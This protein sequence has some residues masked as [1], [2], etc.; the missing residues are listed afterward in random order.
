MR[1]GDTIHVAVS[2]IEKRLTKT[3]ERGIVKIQLEV[4]NQKG[5]VVQKGVNTILVAPRAG[6]VPV[7]RTGCRVSPD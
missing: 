7:H 5:G 4:T 3:P 2:V 6:V 1:I